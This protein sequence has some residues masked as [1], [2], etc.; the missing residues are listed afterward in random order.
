[1]ALMI[2]SDQLSIR[3]PLV[4]E[5]EVQEQ[6]DP[7]ILD[8][9]LDEHG[10]RI[11]QLANRVAYLQGCE[12]RDIHSVWKRN[13]GRGHSEMSLADFQEK[14]RWLKSLLDD[15]KDAGY[16]P[17]FPLDSRLS[18]RFGDLTV[19]RSKKTHF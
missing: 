19:L 10:R 6:S 2:R 17:I 1:M 4:P 12:P 3:R 16:V 13:T 9:V 14:R 15:D 11:S 18:P 8:D 7:I 5:P